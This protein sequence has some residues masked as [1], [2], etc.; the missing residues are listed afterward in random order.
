MVYCGKP[1]RGCQMCRTRRIKC[2][3]TKPTC[4]QC[5]KSRRQ[6]PGYKD[7]F[8]LVFR[9]ETKATERRARRSMKNKKGN[10]TST[11]SVSGSGRDGNRKL[12]TSSSNSSDAELSYPATGTDLT[13]YVSDNGPS[14]SSGSPGLQVGFSSSIE[15]QAPCYFMSNFVITPQ[16]GQMRG[17]FDYILPLIKT[18]PP[19][20]ALSLSFQAV[21]M[22]SLA[23][24]PN[25]RG[26]PLMH[27]A[28]DQYA[29]AL[30]VV[31]LALQNPVQQKTDQT[32][33]S[34][35]LLGFFETITQEKASITAWGSHVDGAVQIVKMRGK[36]QLRTKVGVALFQSVRGQMLVNCLSS[37][38]TPMLGTDWWCADAQKDEGSAFVNKLNLEVA[39]LRGDLNRILMSHP[40]SAETNTLVS[41]I[42][43][44]ALEMEQ[45]YQRWEET[46]TKETV[47][48]VD[49]VPG[50]DITKADVCPG[51]VDLYPDVFS[52]SAW[53][54]ARVS[55][56]FIASIVIRCAAWLCY[57]VD[58]RTTPE[59]AQMSRM[60]QEMIC[61]II[62]SVPFMFGWHLDSE[63]RLKPGDVMG[64]GE[65]VMG[66]K[67][68]GGAYMIWPL[69]S[70]SCSDFTT[71]SQRLWIKGRFRFISD[72]MGLNQAKVVSC[73]Q[74]R[75]PSM[76][77]RRDNMGFASPNATTSVRPLGRPAIMPALPSSISSLTFQQREAM[78]REMW[79][80]ERKAAMEKVREEQEQ[81]RYGVTGGDTD[82]GMNSVMMQYQQTKYALSGG[83]GNSGGG[84]NTNVM[85]K[86]GEL[87]WKV[88]SEQGKKYAWLEGLGWWETTV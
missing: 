78:K 70:I 82:S 1:S 10:N 74:L 11:Q 86:T 32:L 42:M 75:L 71:D 6:C 13:K 20:S 80:R 84:G 63:G 4:L 55:R 77:V 48:W 57:P 79:E 68:L 19:T 88:S 27:S 30:K 45:E 14:S 61:D 87:S 25:A 81:R 12:P 24:R 46:Q 29:K 18:E 72:V 66:V 28:I 50:G 60:G 58:Y 41:E 22:A 59:Y 53:N 5:Q 73:L 65:D 85:P 51:R 26:S 83:N 17:S 35:L 38:K 76:I 3:E 43:H 21:A 62:A 54:F 52:C 67:A 16:S 34:I 44:R 9:N 8:D 15:Q 49:N 47:A 37:S 56:I 69:L 39:E 7:D 40:R 64:G 2:D 23:N 36:K 31:N 33:A